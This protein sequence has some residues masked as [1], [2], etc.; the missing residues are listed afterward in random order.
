MDCV[1]DVEGTLSKVK[2]CGWL[3]GLLDGK[4]AECGVLVGEYGSVE[5]DDADLFNTISP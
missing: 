5:A 3:W 2:C 4:G 1:M